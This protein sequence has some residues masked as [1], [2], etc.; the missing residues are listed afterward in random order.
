MK[1]LPQKLSKKLHKMG[2]VCSSGVYWCDGDLGH[3]SMLRFYAEFAMDQEENKNLL[4]CGA[5]SGEPE[6]W[7]EDDIDEITPAYDLASILDKEALKVMF[8]EKRTLCI[9][10]SRK[11]IKLVCQGCGH[12]DPPTKTERGWKYHAHQITDKYLAGGLEACE[13]YLEEVLK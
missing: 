5:C 7:H 11:M 10:C 13:R 1:Y 8:G 2:V 3:K 9:F 4:G 12:I 6:M